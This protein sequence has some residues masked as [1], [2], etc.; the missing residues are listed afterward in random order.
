MQLEAVSKT[1]RSIEKLLAY[2]LTPIQPLDV[3]IDAW[4]SLTG[5]SVGYLN[6]DVS[7]DSLL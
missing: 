3:R 1:F 7:G 6:F 5:Q 2:S 4:K